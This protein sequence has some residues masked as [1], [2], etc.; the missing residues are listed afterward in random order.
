MLQIGA[1]NLLE[2]GNLSHKKGHV[3]Q[4][5]ELYYK[6]RQAEIPDVYYTTGY[7]LFFYLFVPVLG[8][9]CKVCIHIYKHRDVN[10]KCNSKRNLVFFVL[11]LP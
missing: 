3:L 4:R 2:N 11:I 5:Q 10:K 1:A 7:L 8:T 6:I 9:D